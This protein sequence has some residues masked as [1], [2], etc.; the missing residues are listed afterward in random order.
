MREFEE[1][2]KVHIFEQTWRFEDF[3]ASENSQD[4]E[5][6]RELFELWTSWESKVSKHIQPQIFRGLIKA[7][8]KKLKDTLTIK[9]KKELNSLRQHLFDIAEKLD[10]TITDNLRKIQDDIKKEMK[11]LDQY[12]GYVRSLK[13]ADEVIKESEQ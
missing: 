7:D 5:K 10:K 11:S 8:G 13:R 9:V 4:L 3:T 1:C 6:I 12:V 2:R